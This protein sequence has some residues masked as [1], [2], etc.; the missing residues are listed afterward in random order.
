MRAR[1]DGKGFNG[2]EV[3]SSLLQHESGGIGIMETDDE[4]ERFGLL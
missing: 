3:E 1:W 2:L 4:I